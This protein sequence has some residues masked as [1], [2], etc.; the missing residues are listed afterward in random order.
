MT[1]EEIDRI[2]KAVIIIGLDTN[3]AH[4]MVRSKKCGNRFIFSFKPITTADT[5]E[6]L[7]M[8]V[9]M[10]GHKEPI[11]NYIDRVESIFLHVRLS[12]ISDGAIFNRCE[13]VDS[14]GYLK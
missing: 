4:S 7:V 3:Y 12:G 9:R 14:G 5:I 11:F 2:F 8:N 13:M 10:E 6:E 1:K